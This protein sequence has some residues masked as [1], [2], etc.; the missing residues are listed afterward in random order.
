ML[1]QKG[2]GKI[3]RAPSPCEVCGR[4]AVVD[5][6][7]LYYDALVYRTRQKKPHHTKIIDGPTER[8]TS[9]KKALDATMVIIFVGANE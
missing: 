9:T 1:G 4:R 2:T 8:A 7:S 6:S 5:D 3:S